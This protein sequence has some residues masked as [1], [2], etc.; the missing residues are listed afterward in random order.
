MNKCIPIEILTKRYIK[1]YLIAKFG[2]KPVM[3][4]RYYIGSKFFDLLQH[5]YTEDC[6]ELPNTR[7]DARIKLYVSQ[8]T[9][10]TRG[11]YL[12]QINL[13]GFNAF[14]EKEIKTNFRDY[15]DFYL[16]IHPN[17]MANL[18]AVRKRLGID[19]DAWDDDSMKKDYY[20]YRK[21]NNLPMLYQKAVRKVAF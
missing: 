10:R 5:E 8:H 7:Y 9:F 17:F 19:I 6:K 18:P 21:D 16:E 15:M 20:R 12:N 1:A 2:D 4:S 11:A 3:S 13:K 14:C